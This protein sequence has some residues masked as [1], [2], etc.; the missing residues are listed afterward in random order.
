MD[1]FIMTSAGNAASERQSDTA[2]RSAAP[3]AS[4]IRTCERR[5]TTFTVLFWPAD[6]I[7]DTFHEHDKGT[8]LN[9]FTETWKAINGGRQHQPDPLQSFRKRQPIPYRPCIDQRFF[10]SMSFD[11][12]KTIRS[13]GIPGIYFMAVPKWW[14]WCVS[15]VFCDGNTDLYTKLKPYAQ[16]LGSAFQKWIFLRDMKADYQVLSR[17]YFPGVDFSNFTLHKETGGGRY[18]RRFQ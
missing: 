9:E 8:L 13:A 4:C 1:L 11:L 12:D 15:H 3:F 17:T 7:V 16:A 6:E 10:R 18:S 5:S 14:G 2:L